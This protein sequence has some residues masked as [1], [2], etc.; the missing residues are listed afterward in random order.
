MLTP[1][2]P[3]VSFNGDC[4]ALGID[5]CGAGELGAAGGAGDGHDRSR[6]VAALLAD[7]ADPAEVTACGAWLCAVVARA[8]CCAFRN[9]EPSSATGAAVCCGR[10]G[11]PGARSFAGFA[12]RQRPAYRDVESGPISV[13]VEPGSS[14]ALVIDRVAPTHAAKALPWHGPEI[15]GHA[16][17]LMRLTGEK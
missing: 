4:D 3:A 15:A 7:P 12:S 10:G 5:C 6:P 9:A 2:Y 13:A 17:G 1:G 14:I 16:A 8:A 11:R